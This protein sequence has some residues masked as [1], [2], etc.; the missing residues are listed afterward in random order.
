MSVS[1]HAPRVGRDHDHGRDRRGARV[2]IHAPR[3]GRDRRAALL[4]AYDRGF[5]PRAPCGARHKIDKS[6]ILAA[7]VS[8]HA[9]RVGRDAST[10]SFNIPLVGFNPRAPCGARRSS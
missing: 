10:A 3:V 7:L 4:R 9:P 5:N 2:S 8:I 6:G 1:I